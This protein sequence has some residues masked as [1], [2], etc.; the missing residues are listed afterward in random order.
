M[1]TLNV[2][3]IFLGTVH[4]CVC[5]TGQLLR[6]LSWA[7]TEPSALPAD[8]AVKDIT[9]PKSAGLA[10]SHGYRTLSWLQ[11]SHSSMAPSCFSQ[12]DTRGTVPSIVTVQL[13]TQSSGKH[14]A[15]IMEVTEDTGRAVASHRCPWH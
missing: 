7:V 14:Q 1:S 15:L 12:E 8:A 4:T 13:R 5:L 10:A 2:C 3:P 9:Q 11:T 6:L